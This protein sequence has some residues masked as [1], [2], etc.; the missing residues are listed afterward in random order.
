MACE[1]AGGGA[2]VTKRQQA[3][4]GIET[5]KKWLL[6]L[7][8]Y[9]RDP[10]LRFV[11]QQ[12]LERMVSQ[13]ETGHPHWYQRDQ[14]Q[15]YRLLRPLRDV[16]DL[17]SASVKVR[18]DTLRI[19]LVEM[20]QHHTSFW[21]FALQDWGEIV[22]PDGQTFRKHY[23]VPPDCRQQLLA[24]GYVLHCFS[25]F[26]SFGQCNIMSLAHK[27][28]GE[29]RVRSTLQRVQGELLR[30]GYGTYRSTVYVA[31]ILVMAMLRNRSPYLDDLSNE[32]LVALQQ[33]SLPTYLKREIVLISRVLTSLGILDNPLFPPLPGIDELG[34]NHGTS[35]DQHLAWREW[36]I[37]WMNTS[38]LALVTRKSNYYPLLQVGRWLAKLHPDVTSPDQ[39]T[40]ELAAEYVAAVDRMTIGQW[41]VTDKLPTEK[42]GKPITAQTKNRH[43]AALR[44]FFYDCQE[45]GWIPRHFN[46]RRCLSTPRSI[47]VLLA[48]DPRIISDDIWAKLL[49]SGLNLTQDDL[50]AHV[51]GRGSSRCESYYPLK[52][53]RAMAILWLFAGLRSDEFRRLR[54]GCIRWQT[55]DVR[56]IGTDEI[57]PKDAICWLDVPAHKT[58]TAFTKAVDSLVGEAIAEWE[59][60]RPLQPISVDAKTGEMVHFLFS[61]RARQIGA[62]YLNVGLIP[63]LCRKA[64]VAESDARGDITSHRA[65]S[66]I[67]SQLYN[68]KEPLSLYDL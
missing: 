64:G 26:D 27:V 14:P 19:L 21:G 2:E 29:E 65:R 38:T 35:S 45:W 32:V 6:D 30:W 1:C 54:V 56:V 9:D 28:F 24:V 46:P 42:M 59:S 63:L 8:S 10:L 3:P 23:H 20:Y 49:W 60:A 13:W 50:P 40:R 52:M 31:R 37:R 47:R 51:Y 11:E 67:A 55:G 12:E 34:G 17:T 33:G 62:N 61:F 68:A 18:R 66:T 25:D 43:L 4:T 22:S 58:G 15:L 5:I 48:P 57:L 16:L 7:T 36:C 53:V 39:W 44:I 41:A